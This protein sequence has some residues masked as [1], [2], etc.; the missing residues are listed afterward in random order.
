MN[1]F[2]V[3]IPA[4][5]SGS[6]M[7]STIPK[8]YL[9]LSGRAVLL[10]TLQVFDGMETCTRIVLATDDPVM[11]KR[12]LEERAWST[13]IDIVSGGAQRQQSVANALAAVGNLEEI[14]L[15]HD[16]ARPCVRPEH[17]QAVADA[18]AEYGAALLAIPAR[19]TLK[20]VQDGIV[21]GTLDRSVVWQAQTPQGARVALLLEAYRKADAMKPATDDAALLEALGVDVHIVEGTPSNLKI[22]TQEDLSLAEVLLQGVKRVNTRTPR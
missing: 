22:T 19:D 6:R 8:Q 20:Q 7:N 9:P 18:V 21:R 15:V 10:H 12:L 1:R 2:T 14:V 3:C 17:V 11:V 5:G 13:P 4:A 16:A